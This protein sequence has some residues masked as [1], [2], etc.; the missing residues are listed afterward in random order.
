[1][2]WGIV[3]ADEDLV[4][5]KETMIRV[6]RLPYVV[7]APEALQV[8]GIGLDSLDDP[9]LPD[10]YQAMRTVHAEMKAPYGERRLFMG[11]NSFKYDENLLRHSL[12]RC[13]LDPYVTSGANSSRLDLLNLVQLVRCADP[14]SLD[15]VLNADGRPSFRLETLCQANGIAIQAHDAMHDA[16]ATLDL[17]AHVRR[18]S[19]W[20]WSLACSAGSAGAVDAILSQAHRQ[21]KVLWM[22]T[23]FGEPDVMPC[24]PLGTDNRKKWIVADLRHSVDV[25]DD[26]AALGDLAYGKDTPFR[27]VRASSAPYFVDVMTAERICPGAV[28]SSIAVRADEVRANSALAASVTALIKAADD[29]ESPNDATSEERIYAGFYGAQDKAAMS[30]FHS[31]TWEERAELTFTD[32]RLTDFAGRLIVMASHQGLIDPSLV[33]ERWRKASAPAFQRPFDMEDS[34]WPTL[35]QARNGGMTD[36]WKVWAEDAFNATFDAVAPHAA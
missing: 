8:T 10:E 16:R 33:G 13:L 20:A 17:A 11:F 35:A 15:V 27:V 29:R 7:P 1:M 2:Q 36:E 22:F 19:P 14:R 4:V 25:L 5:A 18:T 12:A 34:R 24:L 6:R 30:R 3:T 21:G 9:S 28:N 32:D 31:A 23:H 26:G